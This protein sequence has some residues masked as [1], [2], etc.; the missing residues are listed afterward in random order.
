MATGSG[1]VFSSWLHLITVDGVKV[2]LNYVNSYACDGE[3]L[4][5]YT[6]IYICLWFMQS[7]WIHGYVLNS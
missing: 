1:I 2:D 3:M 7:Q 5:G 6:E 4:I